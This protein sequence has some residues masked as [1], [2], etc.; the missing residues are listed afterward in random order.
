MKRT[1]KQ[2]GSLLLSVCMVFTMTPTVAF[3]E[4]G[5][6]NSSASTYSIT[7]NNGTA[8]TDEA[9]SGATVT[10]TAN[11]SSSIVKF[12]EWKVVS[13]IVNLVSTTTA[14]TTFIMPE[15]KVEITATY[16]DIPNYLVI[17]K[18]PQDITVK[19]GET[20][21]FTITAD[22]ATSYQWYCFVSDNDIP[23]KNGMILDTLDKVSGATT[24]ELTIKNVTN[25]MNGETIFCYAYG[26]GDSNSLSKEAHITVTTSDPSSGGGSSSGG[27]TKSSSAT[28]ITAVE[29]NQPDQPVTAA[30]NITATTRTNGSSKVTVSYKSILDAI[31]KAQADAKTQ[32][33][34]TNGISVLLNVKMPKKAN[35][36]TTTFSRNVL[37]SLVNADATKLEID[38]SLVAM[39]FN[40]KSLM[41]IL[42]ESSDSINISIVPK[43][44][45]SEP[46]KTMIGQR[47]VY[48]ITGSYGNN[49]MVPS[50]GGD[51]GAVTVAIPYTPVKNEFIDGL[52]AVNVD[53][54]GNT[55]GVDGSFYDVNSGCVIFNTNCFSTYG[56]GY[57]SPSSKITDINS[58]W[59]KESIDYVV[60][61]GILF[62]TMKTTFSPDT[63]MTRGMLVTAL[64]RL[65]EVD[66]KEYTSNNF[67]DVNEDSVCWPYVEWAYKNGIIKGIGNNEFAPDRAITREEIAIIIAN[68]A[69]ATGYELPVIREKTAYADASVI[70]NLYK[71][72]VTAMQQAGIMMG[73]PNNMF[74]PKSSATRGE[75]SSMLQRYIKLTIDPDTAQGWVQNDFG[76]YLYYDESKKLTDTQTLNG[77]EYF[78]NADGTLK[79][80]WVK[81]DDNWR[82]YSGNEMVVGW[83][84][85]GDDGS[86]KTYYFNE[87]GVMTSDKWLEINGKWYYFYTDGSLAKSTNI[88]NYEVDADGVRK[89]K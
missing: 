89:T 72:Q 14:I 43:T 1:R 46:A 60:G 70:G 34:T 20:A 49:S 74:N 59:A 39:T 18:Q 4:D 58:H 15:N 40:Q 55:T 22:N 48:G 29:E 77:V 35:A 33:K 50:F 82:Y 71:T 23:H 7:V 67:T 52:Y 5:G 41:E 11:T 9:E 16:E 25:K 30:A 75:V 83:Y 87:D 28:N 36:L 61:R 86:D 8:N 63:A 76:Q 88:H 78:F 26:E 12:K 64:G 84:D 38:G 21:T 31:N 42:K 56:V 37:K 85:M 47:P 68:F 44:K 79:T 10:I 54:N 27:S 24:S 51:G 62:G 45:L 13:G 6:D 81:D 32:D 2:I 57:T 17:T 73:G 19:E 53:E 69:K 80:G 65:A 3:A 66:V